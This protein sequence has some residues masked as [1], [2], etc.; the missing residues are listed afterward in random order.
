MLFL[1]RHMHTNICKRIEEKLKDDDMIVFLRKL[2]NL[3]VQLSKSNH[4]I[5]INVDFHKIYK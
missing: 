3:Q 4:A 2:N 5:I 1:N